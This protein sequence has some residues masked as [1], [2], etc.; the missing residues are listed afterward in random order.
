MRLPVGFPTDVKLKNYLYNG[1]INLISS[2]LSFQIRRDA[3]KFSAL[4]ISYLQN[5]SWLG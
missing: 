2:L 3:E 1:E 4:P 5:F